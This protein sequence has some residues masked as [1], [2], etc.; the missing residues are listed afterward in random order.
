M[1]QTSVTADA[2]TPPASDT[3]STVLFVDDEPKILTGLRVALRKFPF[4]ILTAN[5]AAEALAALA[6]Q[7]VDVVVSDEQMPLMSGSQLLSVVRKQHPETIRIILTGQASLEAAVRAI[8][9]GE[10][11]RFL[12]KPCNPMD[13]ANTILGGLQLRDLARQSSRLLS[14]TRQQ[15][16]VLRKLESQH[17]GISEVKVDAGGA[18]QLEAGDLQS[19]IRELEQEN[20]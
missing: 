9:E 19:L 10:V 15:Q 11:Y 6:E 4:R 1:N 13:L 18:I 2:Q 8:N 20:R 5:S 14:R 17:P 12:A 3:L 16:A 7:H